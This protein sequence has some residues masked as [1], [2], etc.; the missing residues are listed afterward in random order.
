MREVV[1][2]A[3]LEDR[4]VAR[5]AVFF[6]VFFGACRRRTLDRIG[7]GGIGK[8]P[9]RRVLGVTSGSTR[10]RRCYI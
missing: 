9:M 1:P 6:L 5:A 7:R 8:V 3:L 10:V 4:E 2:L